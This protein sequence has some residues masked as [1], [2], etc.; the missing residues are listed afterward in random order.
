MNGNFSSDSF[1]G[2]Y[3]QISVIQNSADSKVSST[4]SQPKAL[5]VGP[6]TRLTLAGSFGRRGPTTTNLV[7]SHEAAWFAR[8]N[9][10]GCTLSGLGLLLDELASPLSQ[11]AR[12][13]GKEAGVALGQVSTRSQAHEPT[14]DGSPVLGNKPPPKPANDALVTLVSGESSPHA[15]DDVDESRTQGT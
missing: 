14:Y 1:L 9:K 15:S 4:R 11:C 12:Q 13:G 6:V 5:R 2:G 10:M 8:V 3:G 7:E